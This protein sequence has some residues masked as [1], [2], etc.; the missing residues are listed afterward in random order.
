MQVSARVFVCAHYSKNGGGPQRLAKMPGAA[1]C[2]HEPRHSDDLLAAHAVLGAGDE[3]GGE[4]LT[5]V[6]ASET[7][8][9]FPQ[10]QTRD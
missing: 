10:T 3:S 8:T 1:D 7:L 9:D 4:I 6:Q 2:F 5:S